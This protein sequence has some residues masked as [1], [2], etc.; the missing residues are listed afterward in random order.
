LQPLTLKYFTPYINA[1]DKIIFLYC[2]KIIIYYRQKKDPY[3]SF[4][5]L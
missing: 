1:E 5:I 4:I 2:I 3:G